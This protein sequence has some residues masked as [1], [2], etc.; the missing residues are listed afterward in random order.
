MHHLLIPAIELAL[1]GVALAWSRNKGRKPEAPVEWTG[2]RTIDLPLHTVRRTVAQHMSGGDCIAVECDD[3]TDMYKR[4]DPSVTRV[5][6]ERNLRWSEVPVIIGTGFGDDGGKT[7]FYFK[8]SALPTVTFSPAGEDFFLRQAQAE[9]DAIVALLE[10]LTARG[11][12]GNGRRRPNHRWYPGDEEP[13]SCQEAPPDGSLDADLAVLGLKRG[14]S[15]DEVQAAYRDACRKYH[16]DRLNGQNVEPHLV[17]LAIQ[18]FK[19]V[20]A[21][22]QRLR[23]RM[24][25]HQQS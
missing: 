17:E 22:Y 14:A 2:R 7:F 3:T 18:R 1:G 12:S 20:T 15:W 5:P 25:Q 24:G 4:G 8:V 10:S 19:E 23:D 13:Q 9:F 16:P 6:W 21:A 11:A